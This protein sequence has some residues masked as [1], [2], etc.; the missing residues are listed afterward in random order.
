MASDAGPKNLSSP[1][2]HAP[3]AELRRLT[4]RLGAQLR[5]EV[6]RSLEALL[7]EA[8][9]LRERA[10][11]DP[12][13]RASAEAVERAARE[14]A[15][16]LSRF[17]GSAAAL[18]GE[19]DAAVPAATSGPP[20]TSS[21]TRALAGELSHLA[22]HADA[23]IDGQDLDRLRPRLRRAARLASLWLTTSVSFGDDAS[24]PTPRGTSATSGAATTTIGLPHAIAPEAA[25]PRERPPRA[26]AGPSMPP[27]HSAGVPQVEDGA[28][29]AALALQDRLR[30]SEAAHAAFRERMERRERY[31]RYAIHEL[32]NAAHAFLSWGFV[33]RRSELRKAPWFA[34]LMKAADAVMLRAEEA[35]EPGR[36]ENEAGL[37]LRP[38]PTDVSAVVA[39]AVEAVRPF[40]DMHGLSLAIAAPA[41]CEGAAALANAGRVHQILHNLLRNAIEATPAGGAI[42]ATVRHEESAVV[43]VIEDTGPGVPPNLL[44]TLEGDTLPLP[45]DPGPRG[46]GLGL[47]LCRDL[48]SRMGGALAIEAP[49]AGVGACFVLRLPRVC[50]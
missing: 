47:R 7:A 16:R 34:P 28:R 29:T 32:R 21:L 36:V 10:G 2:A 14:I 6:Q 27:P 37:Q 22:H 20:A 26:A 48:A 18:L 8:A 30:R 19:E 45:G 4:S 12:S 31:W 50:A 44:D 25:P 11:G 23:G 41:R 38:E 39:E 3:A 17:E 9:R 35:L 13:L 43:V 5:A 46:F 42:T 1:E 24:G 49:E 33:L 15:G 40:A